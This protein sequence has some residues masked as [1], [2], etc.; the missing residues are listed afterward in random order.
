MHK[1]Q[2]QDMSN[3]FNQQLKAGEQEHTFLDTIIY[4]ILWRKEIDNF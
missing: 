4:I 2:I 3:C 1:K